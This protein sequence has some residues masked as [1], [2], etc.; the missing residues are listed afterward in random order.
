MFFKK[1]NSYDIPK[2][3]QTDFNFIN[4]TEK[5]SAK[6][7]KLINL[8]FLKKDPDEIFIPLNGVE[9]KSKNTDVLNKLLD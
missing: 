8:V 4:L 6:N 1:K 3:K 2:I 7:K 9:Y 5:F